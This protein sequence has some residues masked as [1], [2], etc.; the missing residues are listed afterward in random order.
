ME[1]GNDFNPAMGF[2]RRRGTRRH[3]LEAEFTPYFEEI[4][5]FETPV[6][7]TRRSFIPISGMIRE[8]QA[9]VQPGIPFI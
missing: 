7:V 3:M 8:H 6:T 1:I 2:V 4:S 5:W 9:D